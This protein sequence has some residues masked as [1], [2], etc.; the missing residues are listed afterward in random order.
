MQAII[1]YISFFLFLISSLRAQEQLEF[2]LLESNT[3]KPLPYALLVAK[4]KA[5]IYSSDENGKFLI[6]NKFDKGDLV[7]ISH[8]AIEDIELALEE[9]GDSLFVPAKEYLLPE[10]FV[11]NQSALSIIKKS[12]AAIQKNYGSEPSYFSGVYRQIHKENKLYVRL[13]EAQIAISQAATA[14]NVK[15]NQEEKFF[16]SALRKSFNYE[17]NGEQHGDHLVDL[18]AYNPIQYLE[19]GILNPSALQAY[20]WEIL[21]SDPY[22]Y[23]I[24]FQNKVWS[25]ASNFTGIIRINKMDMAMVRIEIHENPN[26]SAYPKLQS[27]WSLINSSYLLE[28]FKVDSSYN[29]SSTRLSYAHHVRAN[30]FDDRLYL[31][32]EDFSF[33]TKSLVSRTENQAFSCHSNLYSLN[34]EYQPEQWESF[35][36]EENLEKDLGQFVSLEQQFLA[37]K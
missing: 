15:Q 8:L 20:N 5:F 7:A 17:Q 32:E 13:I 25:A 18:F 11:E 33:T 19:K 9:I 26:P 3:K 31:I 24:S 35:Q 27:N 28:Y 37:D 34:I 14:P 4:S 12:L 1:R 10:S 22:F 6:K 2:Y 30:D 23:E 29:L 16:V 21:S 36:L